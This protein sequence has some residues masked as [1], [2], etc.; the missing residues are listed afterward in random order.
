VLPFIAIFR[1]PFTS[2]LLGF[3]VGF[4]WLSTL[5]IVNRLLV[6]TSLLLVCYTSVIHLLRCCYRYSFVRVLPEYLHGVISWFYRR[7]YRSSIV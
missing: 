1:N 4:C 6:V 5:T 2:F 3:N 7:C